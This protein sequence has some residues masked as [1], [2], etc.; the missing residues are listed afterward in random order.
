MNKDVEM[1]ALKR[2]FAVTSTALVT[3]VGRTKLDHRQALREGRSG[4]TRCDLP[5][6]DLDTMIGRV[7]GLEDEPLAG[8]LSSFDCRNNSLA[9]A[10]LNAD[11]FRENVD[12]AIARYG[13]DRIA[14]IVGSSTSGIDRT[15]VAYR[16]R[17]GPDEP[18]PG[19][20][21]YRHTQN[22]FSPADFTRS[23]LGL[24]GL[25]LAV[26]T[27]C[28]SS[29][30]AMAVAARYI[31]AGLA[32]A[33][34]VGGVDCL[35][36]T[37]L[38][39]FNSL[40]LLDKNPCR[41]WDEA[42]SGISLGEAAGFVLMERQR[43]D[44]REETLCLFGYG[45]SSDAHH[46]SAPPPDGA[47]AARAI[48]DALAM[49][50]LD[51]DKIDYVNLH[52]T[53]TASNDSAEDSAVV[54]RLGKEVPCSSTKGLTGHTLGASGMVELI[55]TGIA[56]EERFVP[57]TVNSEKIDDAL[58]AKVLLEGRS[59]DIRYA[60]SNSFGFGGSNCSLILGYVAS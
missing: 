7:A 21:N 33:A 40:E 31:D 12:A 5:H 48:D 2:P 11:G 57:G 59:Q 22:A 3:A 51:D 50:G 9:M 6:V 20:F 25:A 60:L 29:A 54:R 16:A 56:M 10:G 34:V 55:L 43:T 32:D 46:M 37:T 24:S 23:Y 36:L 28:S 38:Y 45:E 13:A 8:D 15:E 42:R 18:L 19:W 35:C 26:A 44:H 27:A 39:G 30:K 53:G 4:L 58:E 17:G 49:S 14:V 1:L 52:G 41:P 47:G